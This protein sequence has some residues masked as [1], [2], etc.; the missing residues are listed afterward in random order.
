MC[1]RYDG[2]YNGH[3]D[4]RPLGAPLK[5]NVLSDAIELM[6]G[7]ISGN[8]TPQPMP[9]NLPTSRIGGQVVKKNETMIAFTPE[10]IHDPK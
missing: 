9:E 2:M 1:A 5:D 4:Y 6:E 3:H 8:Y 10:G 7:L